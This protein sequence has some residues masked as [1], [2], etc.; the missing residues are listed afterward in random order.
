M[1]NLQI[2]A[3][4]LLDMFEHLADQNI[5]F[6]HLLIV[7]AYPSDAFI[8]FNTI[9]NVVKATYPSEIFDEFVKL[10]KD[11]LVARVEN[12]GKDIIYKS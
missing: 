6:E 11:E 8:S 3:W 5:L 1:N 12:F 4:I 10:I 2:K 7:K 9:L